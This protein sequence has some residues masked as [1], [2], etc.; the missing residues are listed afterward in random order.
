M[1]CADI[2]L[3]TISYIIFI[4]VCLVPCSVQALFVFVII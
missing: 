1:M 4:A 3:S 2:R